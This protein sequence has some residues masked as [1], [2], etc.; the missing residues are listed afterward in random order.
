MIAQNLCCSLRDMAVKGDDLIAAGVPAGPEVGRLLSSLLSDM[1]AQNL[2]N[3]REALLQHLQKL[4]KDR[5][6]TAG[7]AIEKSNV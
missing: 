1:I 5:D 3:Q 6:A 4:R 7:C 2:P